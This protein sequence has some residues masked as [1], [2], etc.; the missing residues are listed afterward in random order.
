MST[1]SLSDLIDHD[2]ADRFP[3]HP[4]KTVL[5]SL[6]A[7]GLG[8]AISITLERMRNE[9]FVG[10]YQLKTRSVAGPRDARIAEWLVKPGVVVRIG[11]PV[12]RLADDRLDDL[13]AKQQ[14]D[15]ITLRAELAQV[16]ARLAVELDWRLRDV[17]ADVFETKLKAAHFLKQQY[18]TTLEGLAIQDLLKETDPIATQELENPALRPL[19]IPTRKFDERRTRLLVEQEAAQNTQE[20]AATQVKLCDERLTQLDKLAAGLAEK[21]RLSSGIDVAKAR[22]EQAELELKTLESRRDSLVVT[23][24]AVGTVGTYRKLVGDVVSL[25]DVLVN[26]LDDEQPFVLA[27]VPAGRLADVSTGTTVSLRFPNGRKGTGRVVDASLPTGLA[28][29]GLSSTDV[30]ALPVQIVPEGSLWP[31]LPLGTAVEVRLK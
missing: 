13:I 6:L 16:E 21:I 10:T 25:N 11:Q 29:A 31:M 20:V 27:Y 7:F 28:T 30:Q 18:V 4:A 19:V 24:D 17:N 5:L 15:V 12:V 26:L 2:P 3:A 1:N 8:I 22:L 14:R 23:A 9:S